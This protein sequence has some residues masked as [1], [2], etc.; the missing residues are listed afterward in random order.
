MI[1]TPWIL[2]V[3]VQYLYLSVSSRKES[4]KRK[5]VATFNIRAARLLLKVVISVFVFKRSREN[6]RGTEQWTVSTCN[7]GG[8]DDGDSD[9]DSDS[10]EMAKA[11][12]MAKATVEAKVS[13]N[14]KKRTQITKEENK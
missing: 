1:E 9:S 8:N 10:N 5:H 4:I 2:S 6:G 12:A 13:N 14:E 7:D 11:M 3:G